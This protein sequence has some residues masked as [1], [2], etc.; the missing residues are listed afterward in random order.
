[1]YNPETIEDAIIE[2]VRAAVSV[3]DLPQLGGLDDA[4]DNESALKFPAAFVV[5][6]GGDGDLE[7]PRG[8]PARTHFFTVYVMSKRAANRQA[9]RGARGAYAAHEAIYAALQDSD[10]GLDIDPLVWV[11]TE[12]VMDDDDPTV[13]VYAM[14]WRTRE[15]E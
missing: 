4:P 10:L 2:T 5:W 12:R 11:R 3:Q 15:A 7:S 1:M 13:A 9:R 8:D 6:A 14:T